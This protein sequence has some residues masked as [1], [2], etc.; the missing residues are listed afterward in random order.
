MTLQLAVADSHDS[1][2]AET[3]TLLF[4]DLV[5]STE[6]T[7]RLGDV[8]AHRLMER[9]NGIVRKELKRFRGSEVELQGDG[10][11]LAFATADAGVGCAI[12]IQRSMARYRASRAEGLRVRIGVH[13]GTAL[14]SERGY[15]GS[16][17]I[18]CARIS[19]AAGADEILVSA[20]TA[21]EAHVDARLGEFRFEP[22]KGFREPQAMVSVRWS[23]PPRRVESLASACE[24]AATL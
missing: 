12:G 16:S 1:P 7:L 4:T 19:A 11:L 5:G 10:F 15:F 18:L 17:V 20:A 22:L 8:E 2:V 23:E 14:R 3:V 9:H 24:P 21:G 13:S 6:L